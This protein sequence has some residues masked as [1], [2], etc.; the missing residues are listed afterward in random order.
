MLDG[1]INKS[2]FKELDLSSMECYNRHDLVEKF[3]ISMLL[4]EYSSIKT[5]SIKFII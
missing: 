5:L 4:N 2:N 1:V 3:L